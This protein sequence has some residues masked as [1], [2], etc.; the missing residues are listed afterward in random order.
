MAIFFYSIVD[1]LLRKT[2]NRGTRLRGRFFLLG[3]CVAAL[4][5][6]F[7]WV[8]VPGAYDNQ[9][10]P[11][12]LLINIGMPAISA[13]VFRMTMSEAQL[14]NQ[15]QTTGWSDARPFDGHYGKENAVEKHRKSKVFAASVISLFL[16][17]V[18]SAFT[19]LDRGRDKLTPEEFWSV[20]NEALTDPSTT[21]KFKRALASQPDEVHSEIK[22]YVAENL[23]TQLPMRINAY[24]IWTS[25]RIVPGAIHLTIEVPVEF[26]VS[27]V[28]I[29]KLGN[30][31]CNNPVNVMLMLMGYEQLINYYTYDGVFM[32]LLTFDSDKCGL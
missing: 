12:A 1:F 23:A 24:E 19:F 16:L 6:A 28:E 5:M 29:E 9:A 17:V 27:D 30:F 3:V 2:I 18:G 8:V 7:L 26:P 15:K 25:I 21:E 13:S 20:F 32:R 10:S 11:A 14:P 4:S 22:R 31:Y